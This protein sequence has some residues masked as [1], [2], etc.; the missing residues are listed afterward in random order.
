MNTLLEPPGYP[1]S[2]RYHAFL[3]HAKHPVFRIPNVLAS[4]TPRPPRRTLPCPAF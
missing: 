4:A 3:M 2:S 1:Y